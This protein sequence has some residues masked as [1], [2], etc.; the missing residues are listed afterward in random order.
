MTSKKRPAFLNPNLVFDS[1]DED[2]ESASKKQRTE[3]SD[4]EEEESEISEADESSATTEDNNS[5]SDYVPDSSMNYTSME[6][7]SETEKDSANDEA[8]EPK[9]K[10]YLDEN[11]S[12]N[13]SST[14]SENISEESRDFLEKFGELKTKGIILD[15]VTKVPPDTQPD[16]EAAASGGEVSAPATEK[17]NSE[18]S[19]AFKQFCISVNHDKKCSSNSQCFITENDGLDK[20]AAFSQAGLISP[21][22]VKACLGLVSCS[23]RLGDLGRARR[24]VELVRALGELR[25]VS[26]LCQALIAGVGSN[27]GKIEQVEQLETRGLEALAKKQIRAALDC[28]EKALALAGRCTRLR[29]VR[30]DCLLLGGRIQEAGR[31]AEA[32]LQR[33]PDLAGALFLRGYSLYHGDQLEEALPVLRQAVSS[34]R[35]GHQRAQLLLNKANTIQQSRE[36]AAKAVSKKKFE[37]AVVHY[38][39][40]LD[41][42]PR[43]KGVGG[44]VLL[45]RA[46]LHY[47]LGR[48][49]ESAADADRCLTLRPRSQE[50]WL[51]RARCHVEA[52]EWEE[53]VRILETMNTNDRRK[54]Q[55]KKSAAEVAARNNKVDEALKL[56]D[57]AMEVDKQNSKYRHVL[58]DVKKKHFAATRVDYYEI[59]GLQRNCEDSD[60]RKAYFKKSKEYH[61]DRHANASDAE[62][63]D[64]IRKFKLAKEG[65]E[66][67]SNKETRKSHENGTAKPPPGGWYRDIDKRML[68][69][70][71]QQQQQRGPAVPETPVAKPA[72]QVKLGSNIDLRR[73]GPGAGRGRDRQPG[74]RGGGRA[75]PSNNTFANGTAGR[76]NAAD[77]KRN[78]GNL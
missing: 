49:R 64:F 77:R 27:T 21:A 67:L 61:P 33:Q 46:G 68:N 47:K 48:Y 44:A 51:L 29:L 15:K 14:F 12:L 32:A 56:F 6:D 78:N 72:P 24:A 50:A 7:E 5:D 19:A 31:V 42:D 2:A 40:A 1:S 52:R 69:K 39:A 23:I 71:R 28:V 11:A 55:E 17:V 20:L 34:G 25:G 60:I 18:E 65:Y 54:Q 4:E 76:G 22:F 53:A 13:P 43:N 30:A 26:T 3:E 59:L 10:D 36:L 74:G 73:P 58:R 9:T 45:E 75:A 8:N 38:S 57:E 37:E 16:P 41:A 35:Q 66:I 63:E 70:L 62:K